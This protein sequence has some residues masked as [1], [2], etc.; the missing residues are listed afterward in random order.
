MYLS[1]A[2]L[3][4]L[5]ATAGAVPVDTET[6]LHSILNSTLSTNS[7]RAQNN[8]NFLSLSTRSL[9][10]TSAS[11]HTTFLLNITNNN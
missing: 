3:L 7:T 1:V 5:F 8:T 11:N 4:A 6:T 9:N 2:A 10:D